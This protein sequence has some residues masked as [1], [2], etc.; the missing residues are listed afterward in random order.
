M[1]QP[2]SVGK[3]VTASVPSSSSRH[4]SSG[5]CT[6]PGYRQLMPTM[7][8]GS[9]RAAVTVRPGCTAAGAAPTSRDFSRSATARELGWSKTSVAGSGTPVAEPRRLRSSTAARESKPSSLKARPGS[10]ASAPSWPSTDATCVWT[11]SS[12]TRSASASESPARRPASAESVS[13]THL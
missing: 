10:I 5:E 11:I 3:P 7:A 12:S 4:R 2:R 6:P 9:S 1:S 13:Y 8:M